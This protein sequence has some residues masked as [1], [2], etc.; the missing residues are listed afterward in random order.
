MERAIYTMEEERR[1]LLAKYGTEEDGGPNS[2]YAGGLWVRASLDPAMR[3]NVEQSLRDGLV[4]FDSGQGWRVA[5][6]KTDCVDMKSL[7][8]N[9]DK[10]VDKHLLHSNAF[11]SGFG[12]SPE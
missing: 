7:R 9:V 2:V 5:P 10:Q 1:E 4:R 6:M 3:R 8:W 12:I 11:P